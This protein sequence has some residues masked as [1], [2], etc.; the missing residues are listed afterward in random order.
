MDSSKLRTALH[1][2]QIVYGTLITSPSPA[3]IDAVLGMGLDFIFIDTEHI[4]IDRMLVSWMCHGYGGVGLPVLV[5]IP[6]ADPVEA[7]RVM[8]GGAHGVIVP[9]VETA[10]QAMQL[11]GAIRF[12]PLKGERLA[13]AL[14]NEDSLGTDLRSY[15]ELRNR[16]MLFIINI[17][18]MPAVSRIDE[19]LAVPGLDAV[20]IGPHDLSCSLGVPEQYSNPKFESTVDFI[21]QKARSHGIGAGIHWQGKPERIERWFSLGLNLV[22]YSSDISSM[23]G[24]ISEDFLSIRRASNIAACGQSANP[25]K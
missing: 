4:V 22:I 2:G 23:S 20:L 18:S 7:H 8:D 13:S 3:S 16:N 25:S 17:E 9:Y 5:R 21:I 10:E 12:R 11:R 6:S 19:I 1:K 14:R 24:N 15:L